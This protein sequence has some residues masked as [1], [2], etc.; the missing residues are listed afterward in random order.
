VSLCL[1]PFQRALSVS[2]AVQTDAVYIVG[3]YAMVKMTA[4]MKVMN[5]VA[6]RFFLLMFDKGSYIRYLHVHGAA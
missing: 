3:G 1:Q 6:V 2:F 5:S 4:V